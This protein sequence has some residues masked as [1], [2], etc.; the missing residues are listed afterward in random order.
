MSSGVQMILGAS[1]HLPNGC[2]EDEFEFLYNREIKP[3]ISAV[4][5]FPKIHIAI[6]YSGAL[7][8]WIERKHDE[9]IRLI[10]DLLSRK[11]A[12][13]LGGGFYEPLL[14][15]LPQVDK[16]GQIEMLTT[17][18]RKQF[19]KRPQGCWIPALAWEQNLVAALN[20]C[21]MAYTFLE[22]FRFTPDG[23]RNGAEPEGGAFYAPCITED[24]GKLITVFPVSLR[25]S[26][27][28]YNQETIKN[29]AQLAGT[30]GEYPVSVFPRWEKE[31][32]S[33]LEAMRFFEELSSGGIEFTLPG[34]VYK[35]LKGLKRLY[36]SN[37][38][39]EGGG[40]AVCSPRRFLVDYPEANNIYAKMIYTHNFINQLRGDISRKRSA[41]EELW[42]AQD[43]G[44]YCNS[45]L[46]QDNIPSL[47][48]QRSPLRKA[49]Y[50][51]LLEA[52]KISRQKKKITPSL[53]IIDFDLD[54]QSEYLLSDDK[55]NAYI[56][57]EGAG[58][59]ELDYL[60]VSWNYMDIYIA[61]K[62]DSDAGRR[63]FAD[64]L[65]P[66]GYSGIPANCPGIRFCGN[67]T[68]EVEEA[69]RG[70]RKLVFRLSPEKAV[71]GE[72]KTLAS[73]ELIK[74]WQMKK[75]VINLRYTLKNTGTA[76]ENFFLISRVVLS[77]PGDTNDF[78]RIPALK[79]TSK[80]TAGNS[81]TI[82]NIYS[83]EFQDIKNEA[84]L[85][86]ESSQQ[87]SADIHSCTSGSIYQYTE[88]LLG[89]PVS[90]EAG[91]TWE[92][93]LSLRISS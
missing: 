71:D 55:V 86:L 74:T 28:F 22:D 21:G 48:L 83:L 33:E 44:I 13:L 17:Y 56:K 20:T 57:A 84:I 68:F 31:E 8:N 41:L 89:L 1:C 92:T 7:L 40:Q 25:L 38:P 14:P 79:G 61:D 77:F 50:H 75:S 72:K 39:E 42:K 32:N 49:A 43:C 54:G 19:G 11:Q 85:V 81:G 29:I 36:F 91:K 45:G 73:I 69:D 87:F 3:V 30:M 63:S 12:E 46:D 51:A 78:L 67:E 93:D 2:S 9:L 58:L 64:Y 26:R 82:K 66:L 52:E 16:V 6:H 47:R 5:Q 18:I 10:D 65:V 80:E 62:A 76:D 88:I 35:N 59:F 37:P 24:Q 70:K 23:E 34:K 90:L 4:N 53:S 60:P 15:I 27:D